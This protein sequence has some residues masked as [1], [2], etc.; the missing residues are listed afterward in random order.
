MS[1]LEQTGDQAVTTYG[2]AMA[3]AREDYDAARA[4][5]REARSG[6]SSAPGRRAGRTPRR[7]H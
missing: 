4:P 3:P 7:T 2:E 1:T 5:A 6:R